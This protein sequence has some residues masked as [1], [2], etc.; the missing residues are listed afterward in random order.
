MGNEGS[1]SSEQQ[2]AEVIIRRKLS[3]M[4][5][6]DLVD[7]GR[8]Y[9]EGSSWLELDAMAPDGS[10]AVEIYAH[11]GKLRGGQRKKPA[12]DVLKFCALRDL[13]DRVTPDA[14]FILAFADEQPMRQFEGM[15]ASAYARHIGVESVFVDL[16]DAGRAELRE[17][18]RRQ[19]E[20]MG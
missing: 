3:E 1:H 9:L 5:G 4:L 16:G 10:V 17:A 18:Q 8:I 19:G 15:W 6:I 11:Q 7:P 2:R 20:N 13:T 12:T 14:R